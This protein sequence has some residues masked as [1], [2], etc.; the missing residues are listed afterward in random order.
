M[1]INLVKHKKRL[2]I[3]SSFK[4]VVGKVFLNNFPR[5]KINELKSVHVTYTLKK[6]NYQPVE[7]NQ[8]I[9]SH[10]SSAK[11]LGMTLDAHLTW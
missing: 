10:K 7:I 9:I 11:Y 5:I 2:P 6:V 3:L 8:S 4:Y 1:F